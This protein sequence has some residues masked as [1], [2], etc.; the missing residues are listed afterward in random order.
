[1]VKKQNSRKKDNIWNNYEAKMLFTS[2]ITTYLVEDILKNN[3]CSLTPY[4]ESMKLHLLT[5][6]PLLEFLNERIKEKFTS[7][8]FT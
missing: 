8:P 6:E 7:Y 3:Y 4:N 2:Q 1:M 5:F